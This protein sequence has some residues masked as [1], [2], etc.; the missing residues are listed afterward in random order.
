MLLLIYLIPVPCALSM[1]E[2]AQPHLLVTD[3]QNILSPLGHHAF[4]VLF[5]TIAITESL[6]VH[7][8]SYLWVVE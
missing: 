4:K 7:T 3:L 6:R 8:S 1:R 2:L 5:V